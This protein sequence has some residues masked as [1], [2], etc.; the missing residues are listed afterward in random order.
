MSFTYLFAPT[1]EYKV[2]LPSAVITCLENASCVCTAFKKH[3]L[4]F[5]HP[6]ALTQEYKAKLPQAVIDDIQ[7]AIA[8]ARTASQVC[9]AFL[10]SKHQ[11]QS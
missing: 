9:T 2:K 5:T 4:T 1:L 3:R 10:S 6:F 8:E 11:Q 7:K